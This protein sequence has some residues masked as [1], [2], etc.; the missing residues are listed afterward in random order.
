MRKNFHVLYLVRVSGNMS[1]LRFYISLCFK[2]FLTV[3]FVFSLAA[4]SV[5]Q[6]EAEVSDNL[7]FDTGPTSGT[8]QGDNSQ[9]ALKVSW[10]APLK[11][12]DDSAL[13]LIEIA[14]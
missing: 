12:E 14:E 5:S 13:N 1:F 6:P 2:Y 7:G 3:T 11:R 4:C 10:N 9:K 8:E